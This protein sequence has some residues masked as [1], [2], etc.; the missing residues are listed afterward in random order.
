MYCLFSPHLSFH[1]THPSFNS[2]I[3]ITMVRNSNLK[4]FSFHRIAVKPVIPSMS[5]LNLIGLSIPR[6]S[7]SW[8]ALLFKHSASNPRSSSAFLQSHRCPKSSTKKL[9]HFCFSSFAVRTKKRGCFHY[10]IGVTDLI[11]SS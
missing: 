10:D 4:F 9:N 7:F 11:L 8:K 6:Q 5:T 2:H 1:S 3:F